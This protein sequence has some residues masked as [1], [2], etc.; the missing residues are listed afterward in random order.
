MPLF[1]LWLQMLFCPTV[2]HLVFVS[3][4]LGGAGTT[5]VFLCALFLLSRFFLIF[6][7]LV[8]CFILLSNLADSIFF[9][10]DF[11]VIFMR[12]GGKIGLEAVLKSRPGDGRWVDVMQSDAF[13][14]CVGL[15]A[16]LAF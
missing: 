1:V 10:G 12:D 16:S 3:I 6:F 9:M 15:S 4:D 11:M 14:C 8:V 13:E 5:V 7:H 2:A